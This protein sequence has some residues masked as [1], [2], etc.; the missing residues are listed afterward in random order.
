[1]KYSVIIPVF[2]REPT[3]TEVVRATLANLKTTSRDYELIV[4][5]DGSTL[6]TGFLREEADVYVRQ[7]NQGISR[8][9]NVGMK[10]ARADRVAIINDDI[11]VPASWLETLATCFDD[12]RDCG[13]SGVMTGGPGVKPAILDAEAVSNYR[14]F[15]GYCFMLQKDRFY[16]DFDET[17]RTN[18]GDC[19]Y[20]H[21]IR[22]KGLNLYKAPLAIWHKEGD[23]L[24][25]FAE[26][27]EKLSADS[28]KKF[29]DKWG[30]NPQGEYYS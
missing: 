6:P 2:L 29:I 5:D 7:P 23:V 28:I 11:I 21:R 16:E 8:A 10:L 30:I 3:H 19:D 9:W 15:S 18:C 25:K 26:G 1:M 22:Q 4:V 20:W 14:W 17:F 24:K 13:V 27:Y 12:Y